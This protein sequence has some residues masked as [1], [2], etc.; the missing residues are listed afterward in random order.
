MRRRNLPMLL[1]LALLVILPAAT[2]AA[3]A[4][5]EDWSIPGGRFFTQTAVGQSGFGVVDDAEARLWS[6]F[7]QVGG[8]QNVGYPIS[9]RFMRDGFVTQAFQK[10]ILQWRSDTGQI[11][12]VNI[13]DELHAAGQ[14]ET[15]LVSRQT[16]R[17]LDDL[18][19]PGATWAEVVTSRQ[20]LLE[21]NPA[22][23]ARYF[24]I[25]DPLSS[26]GLPTSRVED[27]GNHYALRTQRALF[28]QWKEAV[29]WAAQGQVT[30][31]NGGDVARELG[32]LPGDALQPEPAPERP[33]TPAPSTPTP[34]V[35]R[36]P[37][38]PPPSGSTTRTGKWIDVNITRQR[39]TAYEGNRA[40][41]SAIV[42]TGRDPY[43]TVVGEYRIYVKLRYD[44]ME[45]GSRA[46][47]DYYYLKDVPYVMYFY[48]GY[49]IHGTYWHNNFGRPMSHGCVNLTIPDAQWFFNWAEVGTPVVTHY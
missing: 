42:S 16:P 6:G 5:G 33:P 25:A 17:Q 8:V 7:Q 46:R 11:Q 2:S 44:D 26:F 31:A 4:P 34:V 3:D 12:A 27:M 18:D 40:I 28:Q 49:G 36:T 23:R 29:P 21:A 19:P 32:W 37:V 15:L 22:I 41:Y 35:T 10:L 9:R 24:S 45:G 14:D 13:F 1:L 47:G 38:P 30:V 20:S 39:I 48:R 43:P